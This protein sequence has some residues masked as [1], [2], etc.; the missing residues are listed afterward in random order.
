MT[1]DASVT[2][3]YNE[4]L[5]LTASKTTTIVLLAT[6]DSELEIQSIRTAT[7]SSPR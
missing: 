5:T 4:T 7:S 3:P 1:L 2:N 6:S